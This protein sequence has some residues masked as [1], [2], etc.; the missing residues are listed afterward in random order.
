MEGPRSILLRGRNLCDTVVYGRADAATP[1]RW[2]Y[3]EAATAASIK[4]T[5]DSFFSG[6][7]GSF[8]RGE[9]IVTPLVAGA[10]RDP[11][12]ISQSV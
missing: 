3:A 7:G 6:G 11:F 8:S 5:G 4:F 12:E 1:L 2:Q 9:K 10:T